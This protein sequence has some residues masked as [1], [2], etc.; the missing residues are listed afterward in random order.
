[1]VFEIE[2]RFQRIKKKMEQ[3]GNCVTLSGKD[4]YRLDN[5]IAKSFFTYKRRI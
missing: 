4:S 3:E 1:M 2:G 5:K